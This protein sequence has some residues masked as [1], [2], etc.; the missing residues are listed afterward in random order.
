MNLKSLS[1]VLLVVILFGGIWFARRQKLSMQQSASSQVQ[2]SSVSPTPDI[3]GIITPVP[4]GGA[5]T[6]SEIT[7]TI[8]SP[9]NGS[10][11][12]TPTIIVRGKT[13]PNAEV[14]VN[15]EDTIADASGNFSVSLSLDEGDNPIVVSANDADGNVAEKEFTVNYDSGN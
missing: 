6:A 15:D 7:L 11:V 14:F 12:T 8:S 10:T 5:V 2:Q 4:Q 1:I 9:V 3:V 13:K